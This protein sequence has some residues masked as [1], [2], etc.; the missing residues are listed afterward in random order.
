MNSRNLAR[1]RSA[2]ARDFAFHTTL[3][4]PFGLLKCKPKFEHNVRQVISGFVPCSDFVHLGVSILRG[5][6]SIELVIPATF[7]CNISGKYCCHTNF[8]APSQE[9]EIGMDSANSFLIGHHDSKR[10]EP[11]SLALA[12]QAHSANVRA[13]DSLWSGKLTSGS[14][15]C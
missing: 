7:H 15:I 6:Y 8:G 13:L 12:Q 2:L 1:S 5:G 10:N 3:R 11:I 4:T 14:M 9:F